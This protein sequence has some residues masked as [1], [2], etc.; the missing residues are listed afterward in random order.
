MNPVEKFLFDS[1]V[2]LGWTAKTIKETSFNVAL[3][4]LEDKKAS[5]LYVLKN[6]YPHHSFENI[7][8]SLAAKL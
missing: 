3:S 6:E 8:L 4:H 2:S 5:F 1:L 7:Y